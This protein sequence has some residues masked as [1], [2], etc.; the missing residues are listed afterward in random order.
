MNPFRQSRKYLSRVGRSIRRSILRS[1]FRGSDEY[2]DVKDEIY[3]LEYREDEISRAMSRINR[4]QARKLRRL[5]ARRKA[6]ESR[7]EFIEKGGA[8]VTWSVFKRIEQLLRNHALWYKKWHLNPASVKIHKTLLTAYSA[9]VVLTLIVI[10]EIM[11]MISTANLPK[12]IKTSRIASISSQ[13]TDNLKSATK[14]LAESDK[15]VL[16]IYKE[17]L[18]VDFSD[19]EKQDA[20]AAIRTTLSSGQEVSLGFT[21]K[22]K[23]D[24]AEAEEPQA[25]SSS[26]SVAHAADGDET[27]PQEGLVDAKATK[28]EKNPD[29]P[30]KVT[31]EVNDKLKAEYL[32]SKDQNSATVKETLIIQDKSVLSSN[33]D[34]QLR[35]S[36]NLNGLLASSDGNGG[37]NLSQTTEATPV[38]HIAAPVIEDYNKLSGTVSLQIDGDEA[39]YTVDKSYADNASY[40]LFLDPTVTITTSTIT[41]PNSYAKDRT[42]FET[43]DGT[44][45]N[46]YSDGSAL[47]YRT[48]A[49]KGT[50]WSDATS[51]VTTS[52]AD[53]NGFSGWIDV[54]NNIHLTYSNNGTNSY[55]FY[56]KLS[57]S[58]TTGTITIGAE[59]TVESAGTSQLYPSVVATE[60]AGVVYVAYRYY[61]SS[62]Y[63]IK[64][65]ST[66]DSG[67][68]W[69]AAT[70]LSAA[71]NADA[72][73]YPCALLWNDK[74]AVVY[75]Y[76]N[77][78]LR[79]NYYNG[80][81]WQSA[82]W[83]NETITTEVD[84]DTAME[85]SAIESLGNN[86]LHLAWRGSGTNGIRY[87][88]NTNAAANW[89]AASLAVT[90]DHNDRYPSIGA[91]KNDNI[92]LYYSDYIGA[93]SYNIKSVSKS[94]A[95]AFGTA[96]SVT[97]DNA[98]NLISHATQQASYYQNNSLL[99]DGT[100]DYVDLPDGF[101]NF[102][103][104]LTFEFWAYPTAANSW[105]RFIDLGNGTPNN[106][107]FVARNSTGTN[108]SFVVCNGTSTC[109]T[110]VSATG[111]IEL[112][113]WQHFVVTES[114]AGAVTIYK[115][116]T[117]VGTGSQNVPNN[118]TRANNYIGKSAFAAD[119]YYQGNI[120][121]VRIYSRAITSDEVTAH[122][123]NG[124]GPKKIGSDTNEVA[125]Y[126]FD[127]SSGTSTSD[128]SGNSM[129]GTLTSA[130][131]FQAN[132]V[133]YK[134]SANYATYFN[135]TTGYIS[136][137]AAASTNIGTSNFTMEAW[138]KAKATGAWR[139]IMGK[140]NS[141]DW[142]GINSS[143]YLDFS[144]AGGHDHG[145]A[146]AYVTDEKWHHVAV[147]FSSG[148]L[149]LYMD[150]KSA[151]S[152]T[153]ET[154][155]AQNGAT[156]IGYNG[157]QYFYGWINEARL[158]STTL[159]A[160]DIA[161]R[162][163]AGMFVSG[164]AAAGLGA[165]WSMNEGTGT[166]VADFS[167]NSNT[168]TFVNT[169]S[170]DVI[171]KTTA[172]FPSVAFVEGTG[173]PYNI[174]WGPKAKSWVGLGADSKW[175]TTANWS[176]GIA[177]AAG[178]LLLFDSVAYMPSTADSVPDNLGGIDIPRDSGTFLY[179]S[180]HPSTNA[181]NFKINISG[182]FII[183][184]GT[185]QS[186]GDI[187]VSHGGVTD[188]QGN[189]FA[190]ANIFIGGAGNFNADGLGFPSRQ[191]PGK[192]S[193]T[194]DER[195]SGYGGQ[196]GGSPFGG[197]AYG[198]YSDP[199]SL[200]SGNYRVAGGGAIKLNAGQSITVDGNL[201]TNGLNS[202]GGSSG[203]SLS[204]NS[205][206]VGGNGNIKSN[207]GT[208]TYGT[209]GGGRIKIASTTNNFVGILQAK[210]GN[211]S[212]SINGGA[213]TIYKKLVSQ[214]YG[215]LIIDNVDATQTTRTQT[216]AFLNNMSGGSGTYQFDSITFANYGKLEIISGQTLVLDSGT[217]NG[218]KTA[219]IINAGTINV[220]NNWSLSYYYAAKGG[221]LAGWTQTGLTITSAGK[222]THFMNDSLDT[223]GI[224]MTLDSLTVNSGGEIDVSEVG[225][226][227]TYGLGG[228]KQLA[229]GYASAGGHGGEGG[230][231][232]TDLTKSNPN[233]DYSN[234][235]SSGSGGGYSGGGGKAIFSITGTA[236][237]NGSVL[238]NGQSSN[239]G[240]AGGS[241][242]ISAATITGNG[243][244]NANGGT[245]GTISCGGGG[246][247]RI[248]LAATANTFNGSLLARGGLGYNSSYSGGPGTIYKKLASQSYGDLIIDDN[249][250]T[251]TTRYF[252][253][254]F[255]KDKS[256]TGTYQFDSMS[257]A[258]YGKLEVVSGQTINAATTTI[259]GDKN[260]GISNAGTIS[261]P[262]PWTISYLYMH[263]GGTVSNLASK[264]VVISPTGMLTHY[265][266]ADQ[267]TYTLNWTLSSLEIQTG[268]EVN[269]SSF[270]Y[271]S[272]YG[273]GKG[274][275]VSCCNGSG[276][277]GYGGN[278]A[279]G[280]SGGA[281][282][283]AYGSLTNPVNNGSGGGGGAA[284][285]GGSVILNVGTLNISG[286]ISANGEDSSANDYA[287]GGAGGSIN[288]TTTNFTG[289]SATLS[290]IGGYTRWKGGAGGGGRI[291]INYT[292][293]TYT[294]G[295]TSLTTA[296]RGGFSDI[297]WGNGYTRNGAAGT[298]YIKKTSDS[299]GSLKIDNGVTTTTA[300][301]TPLSL[302]LA[303]STLTLS[304]SG[305]ATVA[306]N[307]D[308]AQ[309]TLTTSGNLTVAANSELAL[310]SDNDGTPAEGAWPVITVG[311][312]ATVAGAIT[313]NATGFIHDVGSGHGNIS[314]SYGSGAGY[315]GAGG[316]SSNG[317]LGGSVYGTSRSNSY[318]GSGG[319]TATGG[320]GGGMIKMAVTGSLDLSSTGTL[321]VNGGAGG[322]NGGGGSGGSIQIVTGSLAGSAGSSITAN[323]GAGG[324]N[325][326]G[327]GGGR[328]AIYPT[329][330]TFTGTKTATGGAAGSG[331]AAAGSDG[332]VAI[333]HSPSS[334]TMNSP[335]DAATA[336]I[337]KTVLRFN[338]TDVDGDWIQ[339][340]V[341]IATDN[342]FTQNV[343][344][345]DQTLSQNPSD[346]GRTAL[347]S[348]QDKTT[349]NVAGTDGYSSGREAILTLQTNLTQ[350]ATYYWRFYGYDPEGVDSFDGSK[351]WSTVSATR[352]FTIAA[353][354]RIS[355]TTPQ[356]E[357]VVTFCSAIMT[358][359]LKDAS[360]NNMYLTADDGSKTIGLSSG[361]SGG[362]FFS[363]SNC[364]N[365]I[366]NDQLT[367][368]VGETSAS[369]FYK[370]TAPSPINSYWTI[371]AAE[372]PSSGW[373]DAT[374]QIR[375]RPGD[376]GSFDVSGVP[377][378]LTAGNSFSSPA[379]DVTVTIKDV[380]GNVKT[381]WTGQIWFYSSDSQAIINYNDT[382]KYTFTSGDS[383]DNGVHTFSGTGF[384]L[385]TKGSQ[386]LV[387]HNS[388]NSEYDE[389]LAV[390]VSA[391]AIDHFALNSY[392]RA[393]TNKFAM[394]SFSWDTPGYSSAPYNP[395]VT[396]YDV[397]GNV[398]DNFTGQ[399][400]FE[401]YKSSDT[402]GNPLDSSANYAFEYDYTSHYTFTSGSG[403]D[404]GV[405][406]FS[407]SGFTVVTAA[408]DLRLRVVTS[409]NGT[410]YT[411]F[412]IKVKPQAID[413]FE[414]T[415][416]PTLSRGGRDWD[417]DID[418]TFTED[419]TVTA[420]D[421]FGNVKTDYAYDDTS[422]AG[423]IYFYS[424]DANATLPYYK[425]SGTDSSH[426]FQFP[427]EASG[428]YTF[429]TTNTP[430]NYFK[431]QSGGYQNISVSE[432]IDPNSTYYSDSTSNRYD[433]RFDG[434][435]PLK[436]AAADGDLPASDG[437]PDRIFVPVH[438]PGSTHTSSDHSSNSNDLIEAGPGHQQVTLTWSNPF[439]VPS[440]A[441]L[442]PQVYIYRC[443]S[444]CD[445]DANYSKIVTNPA[446]VS[447]TPSSQSE[448]IDTG[449]TNGT[450]YYYK[451]SY[452][453]ERED[454]SYIESAKSISV[455]ATPADIAPRDVTATQLDVNDAENPGKIKVEYKLRWD[456]TVSLAYYK[457][458]TNTWSNATA[459]AMSGD[460]GSGVT[461]DDSLISHT[462]YFDPNV[463]FD[464]QYLNNTFK[465]RVKVTVGASSTYSDTSTLT[466]DS[467]NP[468]N[469]KLIVDASNLQTA[470]LTLGATDNNSLMMKVS[471]NQDFNGSNWQAISSPINDFDINGK[472]N[473]YVIY[474]DA[475]NNTTS[476]SYK[477]ADAPANVSIKDGSNIASNNYRLLV[478][479]DDVTPTPAHY[480]VQR[481]TD[482]SNYVAYDTTTKN[483]AIDINL[484]PDLTYYYKVQAED[485]N[486][487][488][489]PFSNP[490]SSSPGLAPDVTAPPAVELFG[491]KQ[492]LG[493]RAKITWKTDQNSD[494]FVA[495]SKE[496]LKP[497]S[498]LETVSGHTDTVQIVGEPA[499]KTDHEIMLYNLE[500]STKY[501]YKVLSKNE[502][503][504]TGFSSVF[505]FTTP[506]RI[507]LLI[508]GLKITDTTNTSAFVSWT[509]SKLS[510]TVLEYGKTTAYGSEIVD[511]T[512]NTEH[513]FQLKD[514]ISGDYH[515]R[516]RATDADGNV[517]ISDDYLFNIPPTPL[518]SDVSISDIGD[519]TAKVAWITNVLANSNVDIT[520][521]K[522]SGSQGNGDLSTTHSVNLVGLEA[523]TTYTIKIRSIDSYGNTAISDS[524]TLTTTADLLAPKIID[525]K[526][527]ISS[528]G[529]GD[530]I[531]YQL[532]VSWQTEEPA[533]SKVEFGNGVGS[534]YESSSKEDISLNMTHT[535]IVTDLKPNSVYHFRIKTGDK[536]N[537]IAYSE[538]YTVT[539]P[540]KEKNILSI[541]INAIVGPLSDIYQGAMSK[542]FKR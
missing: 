92:Y 502:I 124:V 375:I 186:E 442:N 525:P 271:A 251:H 16:S 500:P 8:Q 162:F 152:W 281:G 499:M 522:N 474:R 177:P 377:N 534:S 127:E 36:L 357:N 272:N 358:I 321:A 254:A 293:D 488:L 385:K 381:D 524:Y 52:L 84:A 313:S 97:T 10:T 469:A 387:V 497:G 221:T 90:A 21:L 231:T 478:I 108:L 452:A 352:S 180:K 20:S 82:G 503:Q 79:W 535:I 176:D 354:D 171:N 189:E 479:W 94:S 191:G 228:G 342:G 374:Q 397:Y 439:D 153:S 383:Q 35:F 445:D 460:V 318:I 126:N 211:T 480:N 437:N 410:K 246:G 99:F 351:H 330:D 465:M 222:L 308:T 33:P 215:D 396:A 133:P 136:I 70:T 508:S 135:N 268:G 202:N 139:W 62:N 270:G 56:R 252:M 401:L 1:N 128:V 78:S 537:N 50:T 443:E 32:V 258:N 149:T 509:T 347:F 441:A 400:W 467:K 427:S 218:S 279:A 518:I 454:A 142:L 83:T 159:S 516:V 371:T 125:A 204:I 462:A 331:G 392:P 178:D 391:A 514:L 428:S 300:A 15:P 69:S 157:T 464:G 110:G 384:T 511:D 227:P 463:D 280:T 303:F 531:R 65:K 102:T 114:A 541:I 297:T 490:V 224:N 492:D 256:D 165:G 164:G 398:A 71:T 339:Y 116:G 368:A 87:R 477:I 6:L 436:I 517:T 451:L 168:G 9:C 249:G 109:P 12:S 269:V 471:T 504:I 75:N 141:G 34:Y 197:S 28:V 380:F 140:N 260:S 420:Y 42:M 131:L 366:S 45:V 298:I 37:Y 77:A 132:T 337:Q 491:W 24:D 348:N 344:T 55:I 86:Y 527:E 475:Y 244:I 324:A 328:I 234:P 179:F 261:T 18:A 405:H 242:N 53:D 199:V 341:Q 501:Y 457:P 89:D 540:P 453:Y 356:Q 292:N 299:Y 530:N 160:S 526:S 143:G 312:N 68:N 363:D 161:N 411:D 290:A 47:N 332:T 155:N 431:F 282:G 57:Y 472:T 196:G 51:I 343:S 121:G 448:Y 187:T 434:T 305:K 386:S 25:T 198:D 295:I 399:V 378:T 98:N 81:A 395:E 111:A 190:A 31:L 43:T 115:N 302:P 104:G 134:N 101:A 200:G 510:T 210:A 379:N 326:G 476:L 170:F 418:T 235:T 85:F 515:L 156:Y 285:G 93:N 46:I 336:Q 388:E 247:G 419:V 496:E 4:K 167:G 367:I 91:G 163:S 362:D 373:T 416:A 304:T 444:G 542:L 422:K 355:F 323:G 216:A 103:G 403:L 23:N 29:N 192:I 193:S 414:M 276:G 390:T 340:K 449:L 327:G 95:G 88:K 173:S 485:A 446:V 382:N 203:G 458:A 286:T 154:V 489:S 206:Y 507:L 169:V 48:S 274:T 150:G 360:S 539:T 468:E 389:V 185:V 409:S 345:F 394:S 365:T 257:F 487:N 245:G 73:T 107:I 201:S 425:T 39:I 512:F 241:I 319:G 230:R 320:A 440:D 415:T 264:S 233:G 521:E 435:N 275:T 429:N 259:T 72:N 412:T 309:N 506:E 117:S 80:S 335:N 529:S 505:D 40:P 41:N 232:D 417:K 307:A 528:T 27:A 38:M 359:N 255:L 430:S 96:T 225:Y 205:V 220:P 350:G 314:G 481:S 287:G 404:N 262:S 58:F 144:T 64:I 301:R 317:A 456:S 333:Q 239:S 181:D 118:V 213:G 147:T 277:G 296:A 483:A 3:S 325:G 151:G 273:P 212:A 306:T 123:R 67:D 195:G 59:K 14:K 402:P 459:P 217:F 538:D 316:A 129:N 148:T 310:Y 455:S 209:G 353:I 105:A 364:Q 194:N 424:S 283:T 334:L 17:N 237:I 461:G 240:G 219:G 63:T 223:Y 60:S 175:T 393:A 100:D 122:Y 265:Y 413:H 120:D 315:G 447:V 243:T 338:S 533:T 188:G 423:M 22:Q 322:S 253:G 208:G 2:L 19:K 226:G 536:S 519:N 74:P 5:E 182:D 130:P 494:S 263:K 346:G 495:Y 112:N 407:G 250:N 498:S 311:G 158:W 433:P 532:I 361:S 266:N 229:G 146:T 214:T 30:D 172:S 432:C 426:C 493:V 7:A 482:G 329:S 294:G 54:D 369:F 13:G 26:S 138:V 248:R 267:E 284:A 466:L 349:G 513:K 520:S 49:D 238:S 370:D 183:N 106:N 113:K 44:L 450:T 278:G 236:T 119:S 166:T 408:N 288:I 291:A 61:D 145:S 76:Q 376:F 473:V 66:T 289:S 174:K 523:K 207:G 137:P 372:T 406:G 421:S 184:G 438:Q 486:G 11:P 470:N 484:D